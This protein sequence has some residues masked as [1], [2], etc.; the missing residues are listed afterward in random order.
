[1][2]L[3]DMPDLVTPTALAEFLGICQ[4]TLRHW[5][6]TRRYKLP[7]VKAGGRVRYLR[8]GII[9]FITDRTHE[10]GGTSCGADPR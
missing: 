3:A 5:R 10:A 1:M 6:V 8:Q 4:Q 9:D 7:Y 2:N